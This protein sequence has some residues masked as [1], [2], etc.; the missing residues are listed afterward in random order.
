MSSNT[1]TISHIKT[2]DFSTIVVVP[3][4]VGGQ[5]SPLVISS[6]SVNKSFSGDQSHP[7]T[8]GI[9][10]TVLKLFVNILDMVKVLELEPEIHTTEDNSTQELD[11]EDVLLETPISSNAESMVD[12]TNMILAPKLM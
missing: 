9:T 10:T 3:E 11:T 2:D 5:W 6:L 12:Q 4:V 1:L 8:S 7:T